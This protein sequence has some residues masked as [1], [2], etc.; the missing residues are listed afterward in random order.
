VV[1]VSD[2]GEALAQLP[3]NTINR[4][5]RAM[6]MLIFIRLT[7]FTLPRKEREPGGEVKNPYSIF[8][9]AFADAPQTGHLSGAEPATVFPHTW[10]T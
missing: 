1:I 10:Q 3:A 5:K 7:S 2:P 8:L 6:K 4:V 9:K